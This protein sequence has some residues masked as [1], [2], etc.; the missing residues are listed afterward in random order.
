MGE[1]LRSKRRETLLCYVCY[2][3][4]DNYSGVRIN[5]CKSQQELS[6]CE[7]DSNLNHILGV[8]EMLGTRISKVIMKFW[9]EKSLVSFCSDSPFLRYSLISSAVWFCVGT[10]WGK[11]RGR[12]FFFNIQKIMH[13]RKKW[14][15]RLFSVKSNDSLFLWSL[16]SISETPC[17]GGRVERWQIEWFNDIA[18]SIKFERRSLM[19]ALKKGRR[20]ER[21]SAS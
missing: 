17:I 11:G 21:R 2:N 12:G 10:E 4:N 20:K 7:R 1:T 16:V 19:C 6:T 8:F 9:R 15:R 5:D 13:R 14:L 18:R 3:I